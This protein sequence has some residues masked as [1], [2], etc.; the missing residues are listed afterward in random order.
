[1]SWDARQ[2]RRLSA[3]PPGA[4]P[5]GAGAP[6][7]QPETAVALLPG[8]PRVA[9][10][11]AL[12][13]EVDALRLGLES[14]LAATADAV[15]SGALASAARQVDADREAL[16]RFEQRALN[17][18]SEL[19]AAPVASVGRHR[20]LLPAAPFVAAA[21]LIGFLTGAVPS[22]LGGEASTPQTVN[23]AT[24]SWLRLTELAS[25]GGNARQLRAAALELHAELAPLIARAAT[26]P[27]AAEQVLAMLRD[28][29]DLLNASG[30]RGLLLDV[31]RESESLTT[32]VV[33]A[34]PQQ[35]SRSLPALP[36]LV[37]PTV[38]I[39]KVIVVPTVDV[40]R[41]TTS[42]PAS[43]QPSPTS[44]GSSPARPPASGSP[45]PAPAVS[46]TASPAQPAPAPA[47]PPAP[48]P[49]LPA[50]LGGR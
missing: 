16:S 46:P 15:Q 18:L 27:A 33:A 48:D 10:L 6:P 44:T 13:R 25:D 30:D 42:R 47:P 1:M 7:G 21:A 38:V 31:L 32:R 20:R 36:A 2:V 26:D 50:H 9:A 23:A 24:S 28:E 22:Q 49:T 8:T 39:P 11:D 12:L 19:P 40:H 34:L 35:L 3:V 29:Q 43:G 14:G 37:G 17:A 45:A 5:S 41:P 4:G